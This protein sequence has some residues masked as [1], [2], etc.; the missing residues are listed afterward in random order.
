[1]RLDP[2]ALLQGNLRALRRNGGALHSGA[3]VVAI[4]RRSAPGT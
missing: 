4:E 2:H 1:M 3:R